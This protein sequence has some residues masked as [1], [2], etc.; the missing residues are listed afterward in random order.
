MTYEQ[1]TPEMV[2]A[3]A[4]KASIMRLLQAEFNIKEHHDKVMS[5]Y[6]IV[7]TDHLLSKSHTEKLRLENEMDKYLEK[8]AHAYSFLTIIHEEMTKRIEAYT[9]RQKTLAAKAA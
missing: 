6:E 2:I 3:F 9:K 1:T 8:A 4:K 5:S 7:K